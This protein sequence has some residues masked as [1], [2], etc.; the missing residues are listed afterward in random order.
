MLC[1]RS[2][3]KAKKMFIHNINQRPFNPSL[4]PHFVPQTLRKE[5]SSFPLL[6]LP[7][8][9]FPTFNTAQKNN[10]KDSISIGMELE[11]VI[12]NLPPD[13]LEHTT[14][15]E[16]VK[17][18][19]NTLHPDGISIKT[20]VWTQVTGNHPNRKRFIVTDEK[21]VEVILYDEAQQKEITGYAVE[22]CTPILRN[23][24]W[25]WV[26][27]TVIEHL[28]RTFDCRFNYTTGLHV[29]I[30][31]G[32]GWSLESL[33]RISKAIVIFESSMDKYHPAHRK[34]EHNWCISSNRHNDN[35][36]KYTKLEAVRLLEAAVT[37]R[38]LLDLIGPHKFFK[39]N[40]NAVETHGTVEFRQGDAGVCGD[41][42]VDWIDRVVKFV[43][44]AV[45][46][47]NSFFER[48]ARSED[49]WRSCPRRVFEE[50]GVPW[51]DKRRT[52]KRRKLPMKIRLD[53]NRRRA[54][55]GRKGW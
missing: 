55:L 22:L 24:S 20:D 40:L 13:A 44:A 11:M 33:K 16:I 29:H 25:K 51:D 49:P 45:K 9:Y 18:G 30:G 15:F 6:R 34:P 48:W 2:K 3:S 19:L 41:M 4:L 12:V 54:F 35:I 43:G 52:K 26:I 5:L 10:L 36:A 37:K 1:K 53:T 14:I 39:Y 42:A 27:P 23:S 17:D 46:T 7:D 8:S 50:F 38:D 31:C 32:E 28:R 47:E 21:S